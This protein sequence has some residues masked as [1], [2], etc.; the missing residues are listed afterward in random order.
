MEFEYEYRFEDENYRSIGLWK[1]LGS[2]SEFFKS[3]YSAVA[4]V[5]MLLLCLMVITGH[6]S[7]MGAMLAWIAVFVWY[8]ARN[9]WVARRI[10]LDE[11]SPIYGRKLCRI[12][13]KGISIESADMKFWHSWTGIREVVEDAKYISIYYDL[14]RAVVLPKKSFATPEAQ[15]QFLTLVRKYASVS[16]IGE[17]QTLPA[18]NTAAAP[19]FQWGSATLWAFILIMTFA[20]MNFS[21]TMTGLEAPADVAV[22]VDKA[23]VADDT[24]VVLGKVKNAGT[25]DWHISMLEMQVFDS[26][27]KFIDQCATYTYG[28]TVKAGGTENFKA[29]CSASPKI[30]AGTG[31]VG[32][33]ILPSTLKHYSRIDV[34]ARNAYKGGLSWLTPY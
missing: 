33:S 16:K 5:P 22:T 20:V 8:W 23:T 15:A 12:D 30:A 2:P 24:L 4:S 29:S 7:L 21:G 31:V 9:L 17:A 11:A 32:M 1:R 18:A 34:R 27:G 10:A 13:E 28:L 3:R 6:V 19:R 26:A 14:I 25:A